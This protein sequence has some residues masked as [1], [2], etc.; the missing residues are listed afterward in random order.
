MSTEK[1][2]LVYELSYHK[3]QLKKLEEELKKKDDKID[4]LE[5]CLKSEK[6]FS[7]DLMNTN[8][9]LNV[10]NGKLGEKCTYLTKELNLI[11]QH[12]T[13]LKNRVKAAEKEVQGIKDPSPLWELVYQ[14]DG[15]TFATYSSTP[16]QYQFQNRITGEKR[17]LTNYEA[18]CLNGAN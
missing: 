2:Q 10:D 7:N 4:R 14:P 9:M 17:I 15:K 11:E 16:I 1:D 5:C 8:A 6:T 13:R 12:L 3:R 18:E